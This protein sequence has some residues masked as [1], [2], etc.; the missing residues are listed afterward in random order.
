MKVTHLDIKRDWMDFVYTK[1]TRRQA[2][3]LLNGAKVVQQVC[4]DID[5]FLLLEKGNPHND[6]IFHALIV[7]G[8]VEYE[9]ARVCMDRL[10]GHP[11]NWE[12]VPG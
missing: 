5:I 4:N 8:E 2:N 9:F 12:E 7:D 3:A 1:V 11:W 6:I 10:P